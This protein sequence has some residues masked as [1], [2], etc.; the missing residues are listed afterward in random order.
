MDA[1]ARAAP[2]LWAGAA[3]VPLLLFI[4][5]ALWTWQGVT[6]EARQRLQ[7]TADMLHEHALRAFDAQEGA[8]SAV[9]AHVTGLGWEEI[10]QSPAVHLFLRRLAEG[11]NLT[12]GVG[13]VDPDGR[14]VA[15]GRAGSFPMRPIDVSDRDYVAALRDAASGGMP[16]VMPGGA[17]GGTTAYVGAPVINRPA[18][19][20]VFPM[21]RARTSPDGQPDGGLILVSMRPEQFTGFYRTIIEA[22]RDTVALVRGA[23][24]MVR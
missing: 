10:A 22:P 6:A 18:N 13:L 4:A 3:L 12:H 2:L 8:L 17:P 9:D 1:H 24:M 20:L 19:V 21:A 14:L 7:R 23:S 5:A 16:G 11:S 15:L